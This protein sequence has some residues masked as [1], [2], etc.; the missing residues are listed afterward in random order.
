MSSGGLA[1]YTARTTLADVAGPWHA[2]VVELV[3]TGRRS[4]TTAAMYRWVLDVHVLP[5]VGSLR[6]SELSTARLDEFVHGTRRTSGYATA[7]LC[8]TVLSGV[9]G[10]AVRRDAMRVNPVRDISPLE[11]G[12]AEP[13][14]AL[15]VAESAR[16]LTIL[17]NDAYARHMDLPDLVRFLLG[18]GA[19]IGEAVAVRWEDIDLDR[20]TV[21]ICRTVVRVTGHGLVAKKPKTRA[22]VRALSLPGWLVDMLL[23]RQAGSA[24]STGPVF[25]DALGGY[26]DRNNVERAFRAVRA[27]T[28]FEWVVP[29]TYRKTVATLMDARGLSARTI[30]DQLGHSRISMTQDVYMGRRVVDAAAA[31]ALDELSATDVGPPEPTGREPP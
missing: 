29:H 4:P 19:R 26:R 9:C 3:A 20:G 21:A 14:R 2:Q 30:A 11:R 18:T 24:A 25:P 10:Y 13:V 6:L 5:G 17:D 23:R 27:G 31:A 28:E 1:Q 22:G 15:T 12:E 7:K 8:R 16:W